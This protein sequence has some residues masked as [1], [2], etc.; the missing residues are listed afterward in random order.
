MKKHLYPTRMLF[1]H[2]LEY[3]RL[4]FVLCPLFLVYKVKVFQPISTDPVKVE[5]ISFSAAII[6]TCFKVVQAPY[7]PFVKPVNWWA[8]A[9]SV[10]YISDR[11]QWIYTELVNQRVSY[12]SFS[13][14]PTKWDTLTITLH[15]SILNLFIS[16]TTN[17]WT[18]QRLGFSVDLQFK[19]FEGIY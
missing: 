19:P 10:H 9:D 13:A 17:Y 4:N 14:T 2:K 12:L 7:V 5:E 8:S 6:V 15:L 18:K 11:I 3:P 16:K 1:F